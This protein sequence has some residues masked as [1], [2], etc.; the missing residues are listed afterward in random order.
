MINCDLFDTKMLNKVIL[1]GNVG[2][3]PEVRV[4]ETGSKMARFSLATN[5]KYR[6]A[7]G[8]EAVH[9]EWHN[10]VAWRDMATYIEKNVDIGSELYVE[11]RIRSRQA[12]DPRSK[13]SSTVYEIVAYEVRLTT[14]HKVDA[15]E[16]SQAMPNVRKV[17]DPNGLPF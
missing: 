9:T 17:E 6:T 10:I 1:I 15:T 7:S 2:R 3:R 12:I 5:E 8:S 4:L 16:D 13:T 11:G 14:P